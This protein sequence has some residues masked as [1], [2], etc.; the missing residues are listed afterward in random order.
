MLQ[1]RNANPHNRNEEKQANRQ[2]PEIQ[3]VQNPDVHA[4]DQQINQSANGSAQKNENKDAIEPI[5]KTKQKEP[6]GFR[7][8]LPKSG[9]E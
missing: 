1:I 6:P 3:K 5:A 9:E 8:S 7:V 4:G 2:Q